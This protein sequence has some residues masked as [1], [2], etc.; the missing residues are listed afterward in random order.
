M[1][2][3]EIKYTFQLKVL[4]GYGVQWQYL[5]FRNVNALSQAGNNLR[6]N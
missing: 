5:I 3:T 6:Q 2:Q 1:L 4:E